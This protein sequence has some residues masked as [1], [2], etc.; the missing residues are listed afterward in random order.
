MK[1]EF[2]SNNAILSHVVL[3]V[4][5]KSSDVDD[6]SLQ[7]ILNQLSLITGQKPVIINSKKAISNFKLR[8]G[9]PVG[10]V[11][12][13]RKDK[14]NNFISKLVNIALPRIRDFR[15]LSSKGFNSSNH[16]S[17]GIKDHSVFLEIE[18]DKIQKIF[19]MNICFVM[20][21]KTR[22]QSIKIL[23]AVNLPIIQK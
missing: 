3:N 5:I 8:K 15:G 10:C 19:G 2:S 17:F 9:Y 12:T 14:M 1:S 16:Y 23:K 13:L 11:V 22:E 7:Y 6:K 4:G 21:S 20:I 18:Q